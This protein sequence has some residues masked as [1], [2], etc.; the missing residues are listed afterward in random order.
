MAAAFTGKV[1]EQATLPGALDRE[2]FLQSMLAAL[3]SGCYATPV[4]ASAGIAR[5]HILGGAKD[6]DTPSR[7]QIVAVPECHPCMKPFARGI[8][9]QGNALGMFQAM[10]FAIHAPPRRNKPG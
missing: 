6:F 5:F 7:L 4:G 2:I 10:L 8:W 3:N 9:R 1:A